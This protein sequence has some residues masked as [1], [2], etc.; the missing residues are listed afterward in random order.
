[1]TAP[2]FLDASEIRALRNADK[3]IFSTHD[4]RTEI[5]AV[6]D[7]DNSPTGFE[8]A[9]A[10]PCA[11]SVVDY[12]DGLLTDGG[13]SAFHME[14]YARDDEIVSTFVRGMRKGDALELIWR[15][16]NNNDNL[17]SVEYSL[18]ELHVVVIK[19]SGQRNRY[20]VKVSVGPDN[21]ARMIK[22]AATR[23]R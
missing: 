10:I 20:L 17:R 18:D 19:P 8:Q 6:M 11:V 21:S 15:R 4:G 9:R 2:H 1:M 23:T 13:I 16:N 5:R 14:S 3:L 7:Q 22:L 12:A